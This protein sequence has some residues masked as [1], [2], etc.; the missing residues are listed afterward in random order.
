[1]SA[2]FMADPHTCGLASF[3]HKGPRMIRSLALVSVL[4]STAAFAT[5]ERISISAA[6]APLKETLCFSMNCVNGGARDFVVSGKPVKGGIEIT[7]T[8]VGGQTR[9]TQV[10]A[11]NEWNQISSTD[12]V[13]LTSLVVQSI[14]KGPIAAPVKKVAIAKKGKAK[15]KAFLAHR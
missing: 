7:V 14:E 11:L 12:L 9:L 8:A 10:V 3:M 15:A 1:M 13:H 5:G 4:A 2:R 6:A